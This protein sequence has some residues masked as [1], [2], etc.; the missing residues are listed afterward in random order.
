[1]GRPSEIVWCDR[2]AAWG[3]VHD[4]AP[5]CARCGGAVGPAARAGEPVLVS[6]RVS[7]NG[8]RAWLPA[9]ITNAH[10]VQGGGCVIE[11]DRAGTR[12]WVWGALVRRPEWFDADGAIEPEDL[13]ECGCGGFGCGW[14]LGLMAG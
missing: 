10:Q 2:C 4:L 13:A 3:A 6:E 7:R 5:A 14:C 1:M 8:R 9:T 12:A 11:V